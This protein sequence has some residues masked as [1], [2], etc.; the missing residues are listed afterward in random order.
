M[1]IFTLTCN[2]LPVW[3]IGRS[4]VH[5]LKI[6]QITVSRVPHMGAGEGQSPV[7]PDPSFWDIG[8]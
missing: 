1:R 2:G 4:R 6:R 7:S 3:V 5:P 8:A